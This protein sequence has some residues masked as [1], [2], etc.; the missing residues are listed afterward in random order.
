M[1]DA[2]VE[3]LENGMFMSAATLQAI[4]ACISAVSR[5]Y[6]GGISRRVGG[7]DGG[8][9]HSLSFPGAQAAFD[10]E[11][12]ATGEDEVDVANEVERG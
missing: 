11:A 10:D 9:T 2:T 8:L 1:A 4:S 6:L 12:Q 7:E 5:R 3:M